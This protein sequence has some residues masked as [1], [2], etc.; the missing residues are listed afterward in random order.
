M[1]WDGSRLQK[2]LDYGELPSEP[3][4]QH[5]I[6]ILKKW[7][8]TPGSKIL[9]IGCGQGDCTLVLADL[10]GEHGHVT[11]IDPAPLDYGAPMTLGEAQSQLK[12][13]PY[14]N[15]ITFH[16]TNLQDFLDSGPSEPL[17]DYAIFMHSIWYL[18]TVEA[19]QSMLLSLRGRAKRLLIAEYVLDIRGDISALPHLIAAISQAE[20]NSR[21]EH[22]SGRDD[23]IQSIISPKMMRA[24]ALHAGWEFQREETT[25]ATEGLEDGR[26]EVSRVLSKGYL[27]RLESQSGVSGKRRQEFANA[28]IEAVEVTRPRRLKV[29]T[30]PTWQCSWE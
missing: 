12:S 2:L 9:E 5:R 28:L 7:D 4:I 10:V 24:A 16:Q 11:A 18:P 15:Q 6:E 8:L 25:E 29:K 27:E 19:L 1:S 22:S 26:W 30:L 21:D 14:G 23:N 3:Q 13:S 20:F 17:Y